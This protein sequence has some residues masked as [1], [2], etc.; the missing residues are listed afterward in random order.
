MQ[1]NLR[2]KALS[3]SSD[4]YKPPSIVKSNKLPS[5]FKSNFT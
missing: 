3:P 2:K 4:F 1:S 5:A